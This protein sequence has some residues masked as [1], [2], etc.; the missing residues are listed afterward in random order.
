MTPLDNPVWHALFGPHAHLALAEGAAR[1]YDP[2]VAR[3]C[4][5]PDDPTRADWTDLARLLGPA[6][7]GFFA[8]APLA[9]PT[10]WTV[11]AVSES[12]Q[13]VA[14]RP[15]GAADPALVTLGADDAPMML[16]LVRRT[17]PGPFLA[18]THELGTYLGVRTDGRLVAMAGE[19]MRFPGHTEISAV[20]TDPDHRNRGLA[21]RL[22]RAV[23]AGIEA[24]G[25]TPML[26]AR[27]T[28][29]PAIALYESLDFE[30]RTR[31]DV[32]IARPPE[33]PATARR[34]A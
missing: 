34:P 11:N 33:I 2:E 22:V 16:D 27:A 24:R 18:R 6:P 12:V 19:R 26:H 23:A 14:T 17:E 28:N 29:A 20:C 31:F 25:E 15:I 32:I 13:M 1:R 9:L 3:F 21:R 8:V 10:D 30:L 5:L 4:G 7:A